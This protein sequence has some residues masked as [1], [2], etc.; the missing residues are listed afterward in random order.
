MSQ[1]EEIKDFVAQVVTSLGDSAQEMSG[2]TEFLRATKKV[3]FINKRINLLDEDLVPPNLIATLHTHL[4]K[5]KEKILAYVTSKDKALFDQF[6]GE[7]NQAISVI[8]SLP[9][10]SNV[11]LDNVTHSFSELTA[12]KLSELEARLSDLN[13]AQTNLMLNFRTDW[14]ELIDGNPEKEITGI[15]KDLDAEIKKLNER[16]DLC[17]NGEGEEKGW[18]AL[19]DEKL[20]EIEGIKA[21]AKELGVLI[22]DGTTSGSYRE[23]AKSEIWAYRT[24]RFFT[25]LIAIV[26]I[27]TIFS[28]PIIAFMKPIVL[29]MYEIELEVPTA[30]TGMDLLYARLMS[31]LPFI[32]IAA[33]ASSIASNHRKSAIRFKQFEM[34]LA[35]FEPSLEN[36][37]VEDRTAA[38]LEFVKTTFGKNH[39]V[40]DPTTADLL[41][42]VVDKLGDATNKLADRVKS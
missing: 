39:D 19:A 27:C 17:F 31:S 12:S 34:D 20:K 16:I 38:K 28:T 10:L 21:R 1:I 25:V 37:K 35:A 36:V 32:A 23:Q 4:S 15:K 2:D 14:T 40:V 30:L 29:K 7:L 9:V 22:A 41:K 42:K 11:E 33:W 26:W 3:A 24:W 13:N 8:T 5:A 6:I 18:I